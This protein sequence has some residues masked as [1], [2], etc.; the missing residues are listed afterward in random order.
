MVEGPGVVGRTII[1]GWAITRLINRLRRMIEP[2]RASSRAIDR[3]RR[4]VIWRTVAPVATIPRA[5]AIRHRSGPI[6]RMRWPI[7]TSPTAPWATIVINPPPPPVPS[8]ATPAP[9]LANQER[10]N[11]DG[12]SKRD[13]PDARAGGSIHHRG[14]ILRQ[15]HHLRICRLDY[16]DGL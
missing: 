4:P 9:R 2:R 1:N 11:P 8:P 10:C 13:Q 16:V 5:I 14:V 7:A 12:N 15:V 6:I 3:C